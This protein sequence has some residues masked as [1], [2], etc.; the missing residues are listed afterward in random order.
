MGTVLFF[1]FCHFLG[2]ENLAK[3]DSK[4]EKLVEFTFE[5]VRLSKCLS[6]CLLKNGEISPGKKNPG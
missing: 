1:F 3:F 4:I 2:I 6:I 5:K